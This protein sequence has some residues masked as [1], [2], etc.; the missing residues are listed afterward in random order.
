[1]RV[2][3]VAEKNSVAREL[4]N[5]LA[6]GGYNTRRT[7]SYQ[8]I[9][10]FSYFLNNIACT[11]TVTAVRGHLMEI[12]FN[13]EFQKWQSVDPSVLFTCPIKTS[14]AHPDL[15]TSLRQL[16][17]EAD[18]LVLWLDCDREGEAIAFEVLD[19]C[20][21]ANPR[22]RVFRARFSALTRADLT[23]AVNSLGQPNRFLAEAV[24]ARS[25]LDLRVGAAFTRFLT[26]RYQQ[27]LTVGQQQRK[28]VSFGGCQT[29]TLG[30]VV[31]RWLSRTRFTPEPFWSIKL[32]VRDGLELTWDRHRLF[33]QLVVESIKAINMNERYA[34]VTESYQQPK[35]KWRPLPLNTIEMT[36]IASTHLRIPSHLCMQLA[37]SLYAKGFI[38]YPRTETDIFH[39]SID[40]RALVQRQTANTVWGAFASN[41]MTQGGM[42][43]P[44]RGT[45]DDQAHPPI[46]PLKNAERSDFDNHDQYRVFEL[47]ARH[48]LA[49]LS[50]DAKGSTS[51]IET[52]LGTEK[53]NAT[54]LTVIELNWMEVYPYSRWTSTA[55]LPNVQVGDRLPVSRV[56]IAS[57]STQAPFA[58]TEAELLALMDKEGI[59]TD[60]T[61]HEHIK[62]IQERGYCYMD[63]DR[64][65]IPTNIGIA[66][67]VGL[68]AYEVLGFHLAKPTLRAN[69]ER[70][71]ERIS[72]GQLTRQEF[73]SQYASKMRQI[74]VAITDNP[75][76]L[77]SEINNCGTSGG[78]PGDYGD[79]DGP[80]Q[81]PSVRA[82]YLAPPGAPTASTRSAGRGRG[83]GKGR[84]RSQ[85]RAVR[86]TVSTRR[87][88]T[89]NRN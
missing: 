82:A 78:G 54:G 43:G 88:R 67:V 79:S 31:A 28:L 29:V 3:N 86:R 75:H 21:K 89:T 33:D 42:S 1:M 20:L 5:Q 39:P 72:Q 56:D 26:M 46:H 47:V 68:G 53:F 50:I 69:M 30:F 27:R 23:N 81:Y 15:A 35:S 48:F 58:I 70:D 25:E 59:G 38:S 52:V 87:N 34:L 18:W 44:R 85:T 11:M 80:P 22:L 74:F 57:G 84:G 10:D 65:F 63:G 51:R 41:M 9:S 12:D 6:T 55:T 62:T 45:K 71:M 32:V 19:V 13:Q 8:F 40:L 16:S 2:L 37:E 36:K 83:R 66:L 73:I 64:F 77:D 76:P 24:L 60:A 4:C 61:M 17:R 7:G 49:C 14:I